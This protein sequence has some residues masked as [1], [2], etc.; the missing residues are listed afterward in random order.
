MAGMRPRLPSLRRRRLAL[1]VLGLIALAGLVQGWQTLRTAQSLA[2]M[3]TAPHR[4]IPGPNPQ[5]LAPGHEDVAFASRVDRLTLRGWLLHPAHPGGRSVVVVCGTACDRGTNSPLARDLVATGDDVLLYDP[6]GDGESDGSHQ[7]FGNL[8]QRDVLGAYDFMV[9]RGY[10]P[11]QMA[12][13]GGS[14]GATTLLLAAPR[15]PA[16]A[17]IVSDSAYVSSGAQFTAFWRDAGVGRLTIW[18]ATRLTERDG[19]DPDAQATTAVAAIP[20]RAILFIHAAGDPLIPAADASVLR[21]AS[22]NPRSELWITP[23]R[24]HDGSYPDDPS[25]YVQR[26]LGFIAG[27]IAERGG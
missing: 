15:M 5:R 19:A 13:I 2:D 21:A 20:G 4:S 24:T 27:R 23:A 8:E 22:T 10:A 12:F 17:A 7:T 1:V 9:G 18:L 6:R 11:A 26:V 3:V 25:L 14:A 16:V